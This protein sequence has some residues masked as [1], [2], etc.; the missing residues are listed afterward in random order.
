MYHVCGYVE[1]ILPVAIR[2]RGIPHLTFDPFATLAAIERYRATD[3]LAIPLMT[4]TVMDAREWRSRRSA[5]SPPTSARW[6]RSCPRALPLRL[7][8]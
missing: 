4:Q 7:G 8:I 1:G 6:P 5:G 2:G 3:L